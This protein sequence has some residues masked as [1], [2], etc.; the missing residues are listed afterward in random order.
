MDLR[1]IGRK[2]PLMP[3]YARTVGES[4]ARN[5]KRRRP[6]RK[7][8]GGFFASLV[9]LVVKSAKESNQR[10][11]ATRARTETARQKNNHAIKMANARNQTEYQKSYRSWLEAEE[12]ARRT[13]EQP[14][15]AATEDAQNGTQGQS[16]ADPMGGADQGCEVGDVHTEARGHGAMPEMRGFGE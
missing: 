14:D 13:A 12:R 15:P 6:A 2:D 16:E 7:R 4:R 5:A 8:S 11:Q 1:F 3:K 9:M 10:N